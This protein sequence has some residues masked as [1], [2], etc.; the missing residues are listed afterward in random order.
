MHN[1]RKPCLA[2]E[3]A[4]ASTCSLCASV[5]RGR[6]ELVF[7]LLPLLGDEGGV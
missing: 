1:T 2:N 3:D 5:S 6:E 4:A 7:K